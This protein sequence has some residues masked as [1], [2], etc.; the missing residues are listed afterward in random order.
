TDDLTR[1]VGLE[2]MK[3][4]E[5]ADV[6]LFMIDARAGLTAADEHVGGILRT[7]GRA[8][9]P[10]AN[11]I[12]SRG[13]EGLEFELYRLGLGQVVPISA[14]QGLGIAELLEAIAARLPEA[15]AEIEAPGVALAIVGRPNVGK[16]SLFNRILQ[17]E[18]SVVSE[19]PG[20]TRD[21]VDASFT[22]DGVVYRIVD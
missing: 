2:A 1:R 21:P 11:K 9:V 16:S 20:T 8:V 4:V 19:I 18:R 12:D 17:T 7:S 5:T 14:E 10:V 3:A 22:R 13:Q 6:I 15:G